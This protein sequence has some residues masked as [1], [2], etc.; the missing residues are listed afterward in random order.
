MDCLEGEKP[1]VAAV[2]GDLS[3][4]HLETPTIPQDGEPRKILS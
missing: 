4:L 2:L 1:L 3:L